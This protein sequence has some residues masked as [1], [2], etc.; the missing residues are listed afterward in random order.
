M[1]PIEWRHAQEQ[2]SVHKWAENLGIRDS[3]AVPVRFPGEDLGLCVTLSKHI[4][5]DAAEKRALHLTSVYA[6]QRCRVLSAPLIAAGGK[7]PLT[8]RE[9]ACMR[10]VLEGK[11]DRDIGDILGISHTTAH[12]HVEQVKRKLG[13]RTRMQAARIVVSF[14]YA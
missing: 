5:S 4:V 13:V 6:L 8:E 9:R 7:S 1:E 14:G 12:F 11:S 2:R 3:F 10:W